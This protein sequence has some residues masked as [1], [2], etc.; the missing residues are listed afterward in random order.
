M[1]HFFKR[2]RYFLHSFIRDELVSAKKELSVLKEA[3]MEMYYLAKKKMY[4]R[5][6]QD[7]QN[8]HNG[9]IG[10]V[11]Y[12]LNPR[13]KDEFRTVRVGWAALANR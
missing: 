7:R 6:Y 5:T 1:R 2:D 11:F 9:L 3:D 8:L 13:N 10:K 12:E 4:S